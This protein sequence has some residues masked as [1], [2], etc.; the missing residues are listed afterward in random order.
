MQ[1]CWFLSTSIN[2][3]FLL[4]WILIS[5]ASSKT[6]L[7]TRRQTLPLCI[8]ASNSQLRT[9]L[10]CDVSGNQWKGQ[11]SCY[12]CNILSHYAAKK[13]TQ[14]SLRGFCPFWIFWSLHQPAY[15]R[16]HLTMRFLEIHLFTSFVCLVY[17][18]L[19]VVITQDSQCCNVV[20]TTR[21]AGTR[22]SLSSST[23]TQLHHLHS[24]PPLQCLFQFFLSASL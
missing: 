23:F 20:A 16:H 6:P 4:I 12:F 8:S 13:F 7:V 11:H 3:L 14:V 2:R 24:A 17:T 10:L 18:T 5:H 15:R 21:P 22:P 19:K 9:R 1:G